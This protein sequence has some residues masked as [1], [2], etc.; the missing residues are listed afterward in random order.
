MVHYKEIIAARKTGDGDELNR[1]SLDLVWET[2]Q[3]TEP[4]ALA[5]IPAGIGATSCGASP[6]GKQSLHHDLRSLRLGKFNLDAIWADHAE[7]CFGVLGIPMERALKLCTKYKHE[8]VIFIGPE[9][10]HQWSI[11]SVDGS[12]QPIGTGDYSPDSIAKAFA[13]RFWATPSDSVFRLP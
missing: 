12:T 1:L 9:T 10:N 5:I 11:L 4:V 2:V 6:P 8:G 13:H 7:R 3:K